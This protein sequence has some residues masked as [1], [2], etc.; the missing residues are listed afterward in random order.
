M[1]QLSTMRLRRTTSPPRPV[2]TKQEEF[3]VPDKWEGDHSNDGAGS[4]QPIDEENDVDGNEATISSGWI[5]PPA[6][7]TPSKTGTRRRPDIRRPAYATGSPHDPAMSPAPRRIS[8]TAPP[9][10]VY[11]ADARAIQRGSLIPEAVVQGIEETCF[12][13]GK[14]IL[15]VS[16]VML[17]VFRIPIALFLAFLLSS[18]LLGKMTLTIRRTVRPICIIPGISSSMLCLPLDS[19]ATIS[20][21]EWIPQRADYPALVDIQSKTF[22]QLLEDSAG[23]P[24]LSL[25]I[26]KAEMAT[27]DLAVLVRL[28]DLNSKDELADTLDQFA[29][30]A[31]KTGR[32][33]QKLTAKVNGAVDNIMAVNNYAF[34]TIGEARANE[35]FPWSLFAVAPWRPQ[36]SA[37]DIARET[38]KEAMDVLSNNLQRLIVEAELSNMNLLGL[39]EKLKTINIILGRDNE[40]ISKKKFEFETNILESLWT[41]LGGNGEMRRNF[42]KNLE[43]LK[44]LSTYRKQAQVHV[45]ATL[46]TLHA[47]SADMED[48]RERVALPDLVGDR[49]PVEVHME[50]IQMGLKRLSEGR[51][52]AKRLQ[53]D[54]VKKAFSAADS[55]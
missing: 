15:H 1:S 47:M 45:V 44:G 7:R 28:S 27:S 16:A 10:R 24:S 43:L 22:E 14:E 48:M 38:F 31:T 13:I 53:E 50:S 26:K 51:L 35:Q 4:D 5:T 19:D 34:R 39:E 52:K 46:E 33:L 12:F 2:Y 40:H 23:G 32:G 6:G 8:P 42:D 25:E 29:T 9:P 36:K 20:K 37:G 11:Q 55:K 30:D 3:E 54:T 41:M 21:G 17:R 18:F 49:V